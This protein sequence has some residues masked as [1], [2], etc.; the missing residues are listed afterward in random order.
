MYPSSAVVVVAGH[1]VEE[2]PGWWCIAGRM[3]RRVDRENSPIPTPTVLTASDRI[4][5]ETV[6]GESFIG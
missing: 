6:Q 2:Q 4:S 3:S 1:A 5:G